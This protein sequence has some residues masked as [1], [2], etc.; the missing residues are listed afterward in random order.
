MRLRTIAATLVAMALPGLTAPAGATDKT[1][2]QVG[3]E[4]IDAY[5]AKAPNSRGN[6]GIVLVHD[7]WGLN[8]QMRG[9]VDRMSRLGYAVLAPDLFKGRTVSDPGYAWEMRSALD[10]ARAVAIVKGAIDELRKMDRANNRLVAAVGFGIGGRVALAAALQG[11]DLQGVVTYYGRVESTPEKVAPLRAPLLGIFGGG[12]AA[13]TEQ[14]VTAFQ[15]AL[16]EGGKDA[17]I[18]SYPGVGHCFMDETRSDFEAE[19]AKDAWLQMRD[20]LTV[21]LVP[22]MNAPRA[23]RRPP[24]PA[25]APTPQPAAP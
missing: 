6:P 22:Q 8:D 10:E 25:P 23:I 2:F 16:K 7:Y 20:W 3:G 1:S 24:A 17:K 19:E 12:D 5:V 4:T 11:A 9:V 15:A 14:D 21:K 13:V 18:V